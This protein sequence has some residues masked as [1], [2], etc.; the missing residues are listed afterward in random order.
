MAAAERLE[1][2]AGGDPELRAEGRRLSGVVMRWG[3]VSPTHRERFE[4]GSLRE[5]DSV[6]L[7]L[8]H[9][10]ER[11]VAWLPGGGLE[12]RA[13]DDALRMVAVL[14]PIRAA[15]VA[16]AAVRDGTA[17]GLSVEFRCERDRREGG[18]RVIEAAR[19]G[20]IGLVRA[21][22]YHDSRVEARERRARRVWL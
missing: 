19:L 4:A 5:A 10:A 20:G 16:L 17:T 3:D 22:S 15:D 2:R 8:W 11:A 21:P 13:D 9:D 7:N 12:L 1:R 14:P 18:V 6:A